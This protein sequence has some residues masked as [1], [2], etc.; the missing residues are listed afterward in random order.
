MSHPR[1]FSGTS[2]NGN[3]QEALDAAIR[4]AQ[5]AEP[6]ADMITHWRL[7]TVTGEA[8]GIVGLRK[9]TVEVE[10]TGRG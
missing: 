4:A 7:G 2:A 8:G 6:G 10:T 9:V 1:T 3:F 5:E